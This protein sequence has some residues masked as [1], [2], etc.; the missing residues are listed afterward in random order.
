MLSDYRAVILVSFFLSDSL[1]LFF[2]LI[3]SRK[4]SKVG[5]TKTILLTNL[6]G[7]FFSRS[8]KRFT[9]AT[10]AGTGSTK[11]HLYFPFDDV[12]SAY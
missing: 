7:R 12:A 4:R 8:L 1:L 9:G 10:F 6:L 3:S 11:P 2:F 5:E